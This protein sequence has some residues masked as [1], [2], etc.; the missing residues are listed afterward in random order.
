METQVTIIVVETKIYVVV[1]D[2]NNNVQPLYQY[3]IKG[4]PSIIPNI[5][6]VVVTLLSMF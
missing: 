3:L 2:D 4:P 6:K 5:K 1:L